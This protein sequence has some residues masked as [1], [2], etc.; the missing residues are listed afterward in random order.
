MTIHDYLAEAQS[1]FRVHHKKTYPEQKEETKPVVEVFIELGI[2]RFF[3]HFEKALQWNKNKECGFL[4]GDSITYVDLTLY[5]ALRSTEVQWPD[6]WK[7]SFAKDYPLLAA[8]K[9]RIGQR[10]RIKAYVE[11]DKPLPYQGDSLM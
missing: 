9:E 11:S 8:F 1:S 3:G 10:P 2:P 4:F 6:L 7:N 5:H